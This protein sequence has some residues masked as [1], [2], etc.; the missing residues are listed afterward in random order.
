MTS[1]LVSRKVRKAR[2]SDDISCS[3]FIYRII[4]EDSKIQSVM[5]MHEKAIVSTG[6]VDRDVMET[7]ARIEKLSFS[8]E[9]IEKLKKELGDQFK[10]VNANKTVVFLNGGASLSIA[11]HLINSNSIDIHEIE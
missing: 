1:Y 8:D 6:S 4:F 2:N 11:A 10:Y 7:I 9:D 5:K 3:F